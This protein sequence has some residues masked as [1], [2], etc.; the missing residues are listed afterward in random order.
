MG[1]GPCGGRVWQRAALATVIALVIAVP[2]SGARAESPEHVVEELFAGEIAYPQER[3]ELQAQIG[4]TR[5]AAPGGPVWTMPIAA[6]LGFTDR[7]QIAMA[8][9]VIGSRTPA[10]AGGGVGNIEVEALYNFL[11]DEKRH[12]LLSAIAGGAFP[13]TDTRIGEPGG[14]VEL[15]LA[16]IKGFDRVYVN[17]DLGG[18]LGVGDEAVDV[19]G[20]AGAAFLLRLGPVVPLIEVAGSLEEG[21][22]ALLLASGLRWH[23]GS[24]FEI[25]LGGWYRTEGGTSVFG[26]TSDCVLEVDFDDPD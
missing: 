23:P 26:L 1:A 8:V 25:G 10:G 15:A 7:F 6:E 12:L 4:L 19:G 24:H 22:P 18:R 3:Y 9:P 13:T 17:V 16:A 5:A 21:V 14:E 2:S 11:C 20:R